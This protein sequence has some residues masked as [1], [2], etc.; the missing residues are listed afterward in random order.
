MRPPAGGFSPLERPETQPWSRTTGLRGTGRCA[1]GEH[2][3]ARRAGGYVYLDAD[4]T[5]LFLKTR[6]EF[7]SGQEVGFLTNTNQTWSVLFIF[8]Q[9]G[10]VKD[11]EKDKLDASKL[12]ESIKQGV[13]LGNRE[14]QR[15]GT[16]PV[17][18][19]GG[20]T[21][22]KYDP[23]AHNLEWAIRGVCQGQPMVNYNTR[24]LGRGGVMEVILVVAP[25]DWPKPLPSSA[26]SWPATPINP[27]RPTPSIA[28]ET[29]WP[30]LGLGALVVG[31]AA[32]PGFPGLGSRVFRSRPGR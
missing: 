7:V 8:D 20:K 32:K 28:P 15:R 21:P 30:S 16:P 5:R 12:L 11:D 10:Y 14:R 6:G 31:V 13:A 26:K 4:S 1:P 18:V 25:R 24:L 27:A 23:A 22:P 2:R 9:S 17:E 29:K 3:A 19:V